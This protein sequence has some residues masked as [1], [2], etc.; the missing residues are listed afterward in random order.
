MRKTNTRGIL[1]F[2]TSQR[3]PLNTGGGRL[4]SK[5]LSEDIEITGNSTRTTEH[6]EGGSQERV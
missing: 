6:R 1:L 4:Y 2:K 3:E 5:R